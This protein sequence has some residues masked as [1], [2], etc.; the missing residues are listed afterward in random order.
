MVESFGK[1]FHPDKETTGVLVEWYV[2]GNGG[3]PSVT[4]GNDAA[5]EWDSFLQ[6]RQELVDWVQLTYCLIQEDGELIEEWNKVSST[7]LT[8][9]QLGE[10]SGRKQSIRDRLWNAHTPKLG[11]EIRDTLIRSWD[12]SI[13]YKDA[14]LYPDIN[15]SRS[16][17]LRSESNLL[18]RQ[19]AEA[20]FDLIE[21]YEL[22]NEY[23]SACPSQNNSVQ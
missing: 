16:G 2:F 19:A 18:R 8:D 21:T 22:L 6:G 5:K 7:P 13:E 12:K 14:L 20:L 23:D 15:G 11:R 3:S 9:A 10:Y 17:E 1:Q 4:P